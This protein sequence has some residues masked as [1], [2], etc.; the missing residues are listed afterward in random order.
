M[1]PI[2]ECHNPLGIENRIIPDSALTSSSERTFW[3]G[4]SQGRLNLKP[5]YTWLPTGWVP[6]INNADQWFQ[7]YLRSR[8][9]ITGVA[10]QG[11]GDLSLSKEWV[12]SYK[13]SYSVDEE[14][15]KFYKVNGTIKVYD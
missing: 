2:S 13:I 14:N 12:E 4:A 6:S 3:E 10:T 9:I 11:R 8:K 7:I 15:W 5:F 1:H